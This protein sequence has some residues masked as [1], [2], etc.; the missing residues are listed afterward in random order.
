MP[1]VAELRKLCKENKVSGYSG[2]RKSWLLEHCG[3]KP[4]ALKPAALK[5]AARKPAARKPAARKSAARKSAARKPA[6]RKSAAR[7]PAARKPAARKSAARK[8]AARKPAARKPAARK[9][10]GRKSSG[11][12]MKVVKSKAGVVYKRPSARKM[13]DA[14]RPLG[15]KV[16]YNEKTKCLKLRDNGTPFLGKC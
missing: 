13:Y 3:S 8:P 2:K 14:G 15:T 12:L 1:T 10:S 7:K 4:A 16:T 11:K 5:P 9:S 6:A